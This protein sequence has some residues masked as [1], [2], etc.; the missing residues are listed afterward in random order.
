MPADRPGQDHALDIGA[1]PHQIAHR[2]RIRGPLTDA[3]KERI[4]HLFETMK[5]PFPAAIARKLNRVEST[6]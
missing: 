6:I 4:A 3:E 2:G 1:A 5:N